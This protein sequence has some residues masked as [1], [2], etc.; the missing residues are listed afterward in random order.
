MLTYDERT[1][2]MKK[3]ITDHPAQYPEIY[4]IIVEQNKIKFA[5]EM[6]QKKM[7][8]KKTDVVDNNE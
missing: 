3:E 6:H 7:Y 2:D 5:Q 4:R 1:H 8:K